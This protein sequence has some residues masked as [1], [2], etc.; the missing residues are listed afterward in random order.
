M[1]ETVTG[2][3]DTQEAI[4]ELSMDLFEEVFEDAERYLRSDGTLRNYE[5]FRW[6]LTTQETQGLVSEATLGTAGSKWL[7]AKTLSNTLQDVVNYIVVYA[8]AEK[9]LQ[10]TIE[11]IAFAKL[12]QIWRMND[13]AQEG[14]A[15]HEVLNPEKTQGFE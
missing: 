3:A 11:V 4:E 1:T 9:A 12:M 13:G 10:S 6:L 15:M 2:N 8:A 14:T 5:I 7:L